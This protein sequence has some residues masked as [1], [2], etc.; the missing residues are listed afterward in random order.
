MLRCCETL[1]EN[2]GITENTYF[3]KSGI[4]GHPR[5]LLP[6]NV[7]AACNRSAVERAWG[8]DRWQTADTNCKTLLTPVSRRRS[9]GD[10][11]AIAAAL[12]SFGCDLR[13]RVNAQCA[14]QAA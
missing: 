7:P 2:E 13:L 4:F 10:G 9:H 8:V 12:E 3:K 5:A 11:L 6:R 1:R 14:R